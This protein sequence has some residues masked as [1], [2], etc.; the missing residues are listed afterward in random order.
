MGPRK[1]AKVTDYPTN[2]LVR[3]TASGGQSGDWWQRVALTGASQVLGSYHHTIIQVINPDTEELNQ[4][5][6]RTEWLELL[7]E[8]EQLEEVEALQPAIARARSEYFG[9]ATEQ[10]QLFGN[11]LDIP[12][13][14]IPQKQ[15][16]VPMVDELPPQP[17][18]SESEP[19]IALVEVVEE[20]TEEEAASRH[21][22][23]L[24]I[25]RGIEQIERTFYEIGKNLAELRDRR[26]YRSTH[27]N[28]SS[29]CQERFQ[30]KMT[31]RKADYLIVAAEVVDDLKVENNCSQL[32]PTSES[33]VRSMKN[34]TPQQRREIWQTGVAE[35]GGNV[36]KAKTIKGIVERLQERDATP[37]PILFT[38]GDVVLI[39][40]LG[41]PDLRK[42]DGQWA[43]A[44]GINEYTVTV[45]LGGKDVSVKPQFLEDVDPKDWA[46]IKAM[47]ERI[48][49]L[50]LQCDLDPMD[51]VALEFLRRRTCFTPRQILLLERM[52]QDYGQA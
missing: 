20:L 18:S 38:E 31:R 46:E 1:L 15:M 9:S 35:S 16:E 10:K 3:I 33:Q 7:P 12:D 50:Q 27:K 25:E 52:E 48:N 44:Q 19:V 22:L 14:S 37:P 51:D 28:F 32:L 43:I 42:Y 26:L 13:K 23:E 21:R 39:R 6:W 17:E 8:G 36:P 30:H 11:E 2:T 24:R 49:R 5:P 40:G 4:Q 47:N 45:A 41:N 29:Y 34:L